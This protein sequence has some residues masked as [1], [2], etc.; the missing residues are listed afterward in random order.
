MK[1]ICIFLCF[2]I[3]AKANDKFPIYAEEDGTVFIDGYRNYDEYD[4]EFHNYEKN[5]QNCMEN[6]FAAIK[7]EDYCIEEF[8]INFIPN[9]SKCIKYF[10]YASEIQDKT[11]MFDTKDFDVKKGDILGYA[12]TSEKIKYTIHKYY[13]KDCP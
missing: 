11:E 8:W 12:S 10:Y 1:F 5:Y 13:H 2:F 3:N 7:N 6:E 9:S 4:N